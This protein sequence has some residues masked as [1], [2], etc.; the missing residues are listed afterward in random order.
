MDRGMGIDMGMVMNRGMEMDRGMGIDTAM[1]MGMGMDHGIGMESRRMIQDLPMKAGDNCICVLGE[2]VFERDAVEQFEDCLGNK[3]RRILGAVDT[4]AK[5]L[6]TLYVLKITSGTSEAEVREYFEKF[7]IMET[8]DLIKNR[9]QNSY[10][11]M[12]FQDAET[13]DAIQAKRPHKVGKGDVL[14]KRQVLQKDKRFGFVNTDTI[15]IGPPVSFSYKTMTA[16]LTS[17][18]TEPDLVEFFSQYGEVLKVQLDS[19]NF[20]SASIMFKDTDIVDKIAL[21]R[22]FTIEGRSVEA[23]KVFSDK[24]TLEE[25]FNPDLNITGDPEAQVMRKMFVYNLPKNTTTDDLRDLFEKYG[26]I[27]ECD[28]IR[29]FAVILFKN[30]ESLDQVMED[31]PHRLEVGRETRQLVTKRVHLKGEDKDLEHSLAVK[32]TC[33]EGF[34]E[35]FRESDLD[36]YFKKFGRIRSLIML[37]G[38]RNKSG[39][40]LFEDEDSAQ[41]VSLLYLHKIL[42]KDVYV[43]KALEG[44]KY[45]ERKRKEMEEEYEKEIMEKEARKR[46]MIFENI[47]NIQKKLREEI[48]TSLIRPGPKEFTVKHE[49]FIELEG[50]PAD[51]TE[52][53]LKKYFTRFGKIKDFELSKRYKGTGFLQY[54]EQYMMDYCLKKPVH[55]VDGH[56]ISL[57]EGIPFQP[58]PERP[59][60]ALN[61]VRPKPI[62]NARYKPTK[63]HNIGENKTLKESDENKAESKAPENPN[64]DQNMDQSRSNPTSPSLPNPLADPTT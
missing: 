36:K 5:C 20:G 35:P 24:D 11:C 62:E 46:Q 18:N 50:V 52:D 34:K 19:R 17:T 4:Q 9:N 1:V 57:F 3:A 51:M 61:D 47:K 16:G 32:F 21:L 38:S 29:M 12:I 7:G 14:T 56:D 63:S 53:R 54:S 55:T 28:I 10:A 2:Q 6:R 58:R 43:V 23:E 48:Q 64:N 15:S 8:I 39:L 31:R 44:E 30:S 25:E 41:K 22:G 27:L 60:F 26:E 33:K 49:A 40:V 37:K 13:V 59:G 45:R 42:D